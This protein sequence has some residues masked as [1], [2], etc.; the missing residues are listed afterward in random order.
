MNNGLDEW[1]TRWMDGWIDGW[2]NSW[3]DI[4][5]NR[6][7]HY[8]HDEDRLHR[9]GIDDIEK[10]IKIIRESLMAVLLAAD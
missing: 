5:C 6:Q 2:T 10:Q 9:Y 4:M 3:T 1:M 7:T 8:K